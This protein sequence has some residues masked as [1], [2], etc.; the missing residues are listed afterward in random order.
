MD[1]KVQTLQEGVLHATEYFAVLHYKWTVSLLSRKPDHDCY[2]SSN[3]E[4]VNFRRTSLIIM[5]L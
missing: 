4:I 3:E 1:T 2:L 5:S